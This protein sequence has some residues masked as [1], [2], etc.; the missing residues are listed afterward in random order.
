VSAIDGSDKAQKAARYVAKY[1]T[2]STTSTGALD[3]RLGPDDLKALQE[4]GL[5]PHHLRLADTSL[6]LGGKKKLAHLNLARAANALGYGGHVISKSR[7]YSTTFTAL[8][9]ARHEHLVRKAMARSSGT[10]RVLYDKWSYAGSGYPLR[11]DCL[12]ATDWAESAIEARWYAWDAITDLEFE[13][14][15]AAA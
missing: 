1:T 14:R 6:G 12:I 11:G 9:T 10:T 2:A 5:S 3:K 15:R 4:S 8:R 13:A 7:R